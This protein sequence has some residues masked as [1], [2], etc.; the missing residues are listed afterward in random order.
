LATKTSSEPALAPKPALPWKL[1][2]KTT[3][4]AALTATASAC[5]RSVPSPWVPSHW[6]V[7]VHPEQPPLVLLELLVE[8]LE[9]LVVEELVVLLL[10]LLVVVLEELELLVV[11]ELLV[12]LLLELLVEELVVEELLV[13]LLEPPVPPVP[14]VPPAEVVAEELPPWPVVGFSHTHAPTAA[15]V[16]S[17]TPIAASPVRI[18]TPP[19]ARRSQARSTAAPRPSPAKRPSAR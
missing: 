3:S 6:V 13:V 16:P 2:A 15:L 11:E 1:P 12:V 19:R 5:W 4:P 7:P 10:E 18:R 14:P 17:T 9:L 8:V